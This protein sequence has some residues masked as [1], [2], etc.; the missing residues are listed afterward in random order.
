LVSKKQKNKKNTQNVEKSK[1]SKKQ[2]LLLKHHLTTQQLNWNLSQSIFKWK[3]KSSFFS[4]SWLQ[5]R[6]S[7]QNECLLRERAN[8]Q[9]ISMKNWKTRKNKNMTIYL[10]DI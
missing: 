3:L 1:I 5:F 2:K 4:F 10:D 9:A 8:E 6:F 7:K